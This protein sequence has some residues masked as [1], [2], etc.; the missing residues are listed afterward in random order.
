MAF[1]EGNGR[2]DQQGVELRGTRDAHNQDHD[3]GVAESSSSITTSPDRNEN[4][5]QHANLRM[6]AICTYILTISTANCE[7]TRD[8]KFQL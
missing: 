2:A 3:R 5:Y 6:Y 4:G 1:C 8:G 7:I